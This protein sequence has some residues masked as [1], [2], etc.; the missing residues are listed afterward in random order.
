MTPILRAG[1]RS[2]LLVL[3][4]LGTPGA[5]WAQP[6][7]DPREEAMEERAMPGMMEMP[8]MAPQG[9]QRMGSMPM[10]SMPMGSMQPMTCTCSSALRGAGGAALLVL[11]TLVAGSAA[12]ALIALALFLLR[13]SRRAPA[14]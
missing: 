11:T 4:L 9:E 5:L 7:A 10:G 6:A 12:A 8:G 2:L 3:L 14:T 1:L 13:R